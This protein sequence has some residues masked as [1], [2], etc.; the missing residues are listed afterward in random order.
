LYVR[1]ITG[2]L[3]IGFGVVGG[4]NKGLTVGFGV[5]LTAAFLGAWL[6]LFLTLVL[7]LRASM[8]I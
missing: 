1:L 5:G 3:I 7:P 4:K 8:I 2:F 6:M